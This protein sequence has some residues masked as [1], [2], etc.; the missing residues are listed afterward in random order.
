MRAVYNDEISPFEELFEPLKN[1]VELQHMFTNRFFV[2]TGESVNYGLKE[3]RYFG[4]KIWSIVPSDIDPLRA[5][6]TKW[7][8]TLKQFVGNLPTNCLSVFGHFVN[9]ALKGLKVV[10]YFNNSQKQFCYRF[11]RLVAVDSAKVTY[12]K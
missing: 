10:E 4:A 5:N 6:P 2:A 7:P 11:F 3:L 12:N 9:F 8:N 1:S